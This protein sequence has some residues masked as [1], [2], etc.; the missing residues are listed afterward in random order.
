LSQA[1]AALSNDFCLCAARSRIVFC[2]RSSASVQCRPQNNRVRR[3]D[4]SEGAVITN[5]RTL[6][7]VIVL[8]AGAAYLGLSYFLAASQQRSL[9]ATLLGLAPF[10]AAAFALAWNFRARWL[11]LAL[12]GVC[13]IAIALSF[14]LLRSHAHWLYF[15]QHAGAMSAL[16]VAF[17]V[18]LGGD[19]AQ[20]LCSRMAAAMQGGRSDAALMRYTWKVTLAWT[21]FFILCALVSVLLFALA[22]IEIWFAFANLLTPVLLAAMFAGEY[23]VR[24]YALPGHAH[25]G[26]E[27]I[28][29]T[30]LEHSKPHKT[31]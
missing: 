31:P 28:I 18:T 3:G 19:H 1:H 13:A 30:F 23:L 7:L 4:C 11:A 17:G 27:K 6:H 2:R 5:R 21:V 9:A 25:L 10:A 16:A 26:I 24:L 15:V 29:Q 20:A 12:Y 8:T 14:D 22:P